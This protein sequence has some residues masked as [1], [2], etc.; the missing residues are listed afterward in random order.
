MNRYKKLGESLIY[1]SQYEFSLV[2][3]ELEFQFKLSK[4]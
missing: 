4:K 1:L 2:K 3:T